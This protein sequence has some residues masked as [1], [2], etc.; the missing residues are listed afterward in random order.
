MSSILLTAPAGA[1]KT[2]YAVQQIVQYKQQQPWQP[3]W[4]LLP[5][6]LQIN[7][8]RERLLHAPV[9]FG[10]HYFTFYQLYSHLLAQMG[11]FQRQMQGGSVYRV[12]RQIVDTLDL[13]YFGPIADKPGFINLLVQFI[14]ELKQARVSPDEFKMYATTP[15]DCDLAAIYETYQG[16]V[17]TGNTVDREGAGWLALEHLPEHRHMLA[18]VG[19]LVVDGF[20]QFS[21]LQRQLLERVA[22]GV[23]HTLVTLTYEEARAESVHR[24]F[25]RTYQDLLDLQIEWEVRPLA[26]L[27]ETDQHPALQHLEQ[28]F[29][30][31][32]TEP[33]AGEG[34]VCCIEAPDVEQEVRGVLRRV[35]AL[36]LDAT[37][38]DDV[39]LLTRDMKRY[40]DL[41]RSVGLT[42]GVPLVFRR[43]TQLAQNP[44]IKAIMS[45]LELHRD[46]RRQDVLNVLRSPYFA[47]SELTP[48][49]IDMLEY[50]SLKY[51]VIRGTHDWWNALERAVIKRE[52][53][54]ELLD[55]VTA[56]FEHITPVYSAPVDQHMRW[57][58][59]LLGP[60]PANED[61]SR[62]LVDGHLQFYQ[63]ARDV[64]EDRTG[65][66]VM[67]NDLYAMHGFR[68]CLRDVLLA[69]ELLEEEFS[70]WD[71]FWQ[72]LE[73]A[74]E[75][76]YA[77]P[78]G[79]EYRHGR[80]LVTDT[81]EGLG[82]PHE[83]VFILGLAEGVFPAQRRED[84]LYS[85]RERVAFMQGTGHELQTTSERQDDTSIFYQ[86]MAQARQT[87]TLSR[88]TLDDN[89]NPWPP[90]VLW[91]AV[92][93]LVSDIE[94]IHYRAGEPPR[95]LEAANLR[96]AG[97]ALAAVLADPA[98]HDSD[99][100]RRA[101]NWL[102]FR[103][104]YRTRWS[105]V[106][107]GRRIE[108]RRSDPRQ[109]FDHYSGILGD[110]ALIEQV[111]FRLGPSR[112]WSASQFNDYGYCPFRFFSKRVLRLEALEE[113][114]EGYDVAQLGSL[115]HE[116]LE[117][118]YQRI[119]N[120]KLAIRPE[121][122]PDAL[123]ILE[124]EADRI[125]PEA[126]RTW[127]F[128]VTSLWAQEQAEIRRRLRLLI[129]RD[130]S[131]DIDSPFIIN[132]RARSPHPVAVAASQGERYVHELE[133]DF[134]IEE[135][136]TPPAIIHGPAGRIR[137]RGLIDRID[138]V[139]D[140]LIVIDY[141]SGTQTPT[142][143][144][145]EAGRNF[146]MMLYLMAAKQ[147]YP[148]L[149]VEAGMFWSIRTRQGKGEIQA[150]DSRLEEARE[151]LHRYILD[152]RDGIFPVKP[153]QGQC[154]KYCEFANMCRIKSTRVYDDNAGDAA[155]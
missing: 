126:P 139:G 138:R 137:A 85:D 29:M 70:T 72:E 71:Q 154:F 26:P 88:P 75:Q 119:K 99:L 18:G 134:G 48:N 74:V 58:E 121:N 93:S 136:A 51:Q 57:L 128:R 14:Y 20:L 73:L 16:W 46:F 97:V 120:E 22:E 12:V 31:A 27:P 21:P 69:A 89:A 110:P 7:R 153:N 127:G 133:A 86:C 103:S 39:L 122:L 132:P 40:A 95:L 66:T 13:H 81:L 91:Q 44:A 135:S 125:F 150:D 151:K 130:F 76:R 106:E 53:D 4:I 6:M 10:L 45:L 64:E 59:D 56:F 105:A 19:M 113:P 63:Q 41:V 67:V 15:K 117:H 118:T 79:G 143:Q 24:A 52:C 131:D 142:N 108:E 82:L 47:F 83:H 111:A 33:I 87:L 155:E 8:F 77:L 90:S 43:G 50:I 30:A 1:G 35:K 102:R 107:R 123:A 62:L 17:R 124:E 84:P 42:Y 49:D 100:L 32:E 68:Q 54:E 96:E 11:L 34:V 23:Q 36:L 140:S 147:L 152:A 37:R 9:V 109:D 65:L 149:T 78:T 2:T 28:H 112:V 144:D 94:V 129:E 146:Q 25:S 116:I 141:K 55:R 148:Q 80:V 114:A 101:Y 60:D 61:A 104:E 98:E 145:I 3:V 5:T 38:P 92:K 115:Q